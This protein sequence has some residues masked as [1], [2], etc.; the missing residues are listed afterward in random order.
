MKES[1]ITTLVIIIFSAA[2]SLSSV[3]QAASEPTIGDEITV[4]IDI[5]PDARRSK[6]IMLGISANGTLAKY[7][8]LGVP[9][10]TP[11]YVYYVISDDGNS[12][13][14]DLTNRPDLVTVVVQATGKHVLVKGWVYLITTVTPT[15]Q[16]LEWALIEVSTLTVA[17]E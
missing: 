4:T 8:L 15:G 2:L 12:Y 17:T 3:V 11:P 5:N 7:D 14:L 6:Q 16:E 9:G 10:T 13:G 1:S